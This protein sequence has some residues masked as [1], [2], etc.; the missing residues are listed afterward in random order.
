M[1]AFGQVGSFCLHELTNQMSARAS[2]LEGDY[3]TAH[4]RLITN[5]EEIAFY[6]G[7]TREKA[8]ITRLFRAVFLHARYSYYMQYLVGSKFL[9]RFSEF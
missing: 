8:I 7:S 3:R 2:A 1:P 6:D 9:A 5:S 4:Q